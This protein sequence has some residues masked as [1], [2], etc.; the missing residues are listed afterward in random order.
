MSFSWFA[1]RFITLICETYLWGIVSLG[2]LLLTGTNLGQIIALAQT[3]GNTFFSFVL[4]API[5]YVIFMT[6]YILLRKFTKS[7]I[8]PFEDVLHSVVRGLTNPFQQ[9]YLF[10]LIVTRKHIIQDDSALHNF[11]DFLQVLLP[12]LWY[13]LLAVFIVRGFLAIH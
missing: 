4:W 10:I 5:R 8:S 13:F 2:A 9:A 12:F 7:A 11:E 1:W 3:A 6:V